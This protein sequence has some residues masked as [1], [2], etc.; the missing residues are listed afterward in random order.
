MRRFGC[1]TAP[2]LDE[3]AT[4]KLL[5]DG[6]KVFAEAFDKLLGAVEYRC[7]CKASTTRD[8]QSAALS[9]PVETDV[10]KSLEDW[11]AT[12]KVRRLWRAT[13]RCGPARTKAVGSAGSE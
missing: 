2:D 6:V 12:G 7:K 13:R 11:K 1:S 10:R 9:K 8:R 3:G 4:A 5:D